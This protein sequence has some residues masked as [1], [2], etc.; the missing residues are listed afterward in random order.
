MGK[1][2]RQTVGYRYYMGL[3]M[4]L[5]VAATNMLE[6]QYGERTVW[7]GIQSGGQVY[8][9]APIL[10]GGD[11]KE[12]GVVGALDLF[13]GAEFQPA[14]DYL[15]TVMAKQTPLPAFRGVF[16]LVFRRVQYAALNHYMKNWAVRLER[17]S[18]AFSTRPTTGEC[19]A[20]II[21]EV[22]TNQDWG[23]KIP[24][25]LVDRQS[26]A[27]AS[28]QLFCE[29]FGLNFIWDRQTSHLD[30]IGQVI[31]HIGGV[32]YTD[33]H[34]GEFKLKLIRGDYDV[35]LIPIFNESN[36]IS[37]DSFQRSGWSET[38]NEIVVVYTDAATFKPATLS[39]QNMAN[40][41]I[42]GALI[43][44][45]VNYPGITNPQLAHK[46]AMR[47]L[48]I[49]STPLS[50]LRLKLDRRA[51][52]LIPGDVFK[53]QLSSQG[54]AN[55]VYRVANV[56]YGT[57]A[58]ATV[59]VDAVEDV[60]GLGL[61]EFSPTVIVDE[62]TNFN[63]QAPLFSTVYEAA[64]WEISRF[65]SRADLTVLDD[66]DTY[67]G[68]LAVALNNNQLNYNFSTG[69]NISALQQAVVGTYAS[70][71]TLNS[72]LNLTVHDAIAISYTNLSR[73]NEID[74]GDYGYLLDVGFNIIEAVLVLAID[75]DLK[76][77]SFARGI[78][79]TLPAAHLV[80]TKLVI[81]SD[82]EA[83]DE[84]VRI[85]NET[86]YCA[87][88]AETAQALGAQLSPSNGQSLTLISRAGRPYPPANVKINNLS[89]PKVLMGDLNITWAER[90]RLS[91][92]AYLIQ[93]ADGNVL[94][95][96]GQTYNVKVFGETDNLI[97][98]LTGIIGQARTYTSAQEVLHSNYII[99]RAN[100]SLKVIIE[101]ERESL[102]S[103]QRWSLQF[104]RAD[105]GYNYGR[106]YGGI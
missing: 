23:A 101:A 44:K 32:L 98:E 8:L 52:F 99:A 19:P 96:V 30:F 14:S 64:Y 65:L 42:Q 81:V 60:F 72:A 92:T 17:F 41:A 90:N 61:A 35:N 24:S 13:D 67:V 79:D 89:Y 76:T 86:V 38:V 21:Y 82:D 106:Y 7:T 40:I 31:D 75:T 95:E 58:D 100:G 29:Q 62:E 37:L 39:V 11:K 91:Q 94:P 28:Q 51:Y 74:V 27:I 56:D 6:L 78:L 85:L 73:D 104:E 63:A 70:A 16:S 50:K 22:L 46:C 66:L 77:L 88:Q 83:V 34:T 103:W 9:N 33:L 97:A 10:F 20:S 3:H 45:T 59:T 80:N 54:L 55:I 47:D 49:S 4:P 53:L 68:A 102:K 48:K 12:G 1:R 25:A 93:Q 15:Q 84:T 18:G 69:N 5:C 36:I 71:I 2:K 105:Y 57:D 43:S 87:L 26:F